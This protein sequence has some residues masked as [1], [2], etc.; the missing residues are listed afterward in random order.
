MTRCAPGI[1]GW[2]AQGEDAGLAADLDVGGGRRPAPGSVGHGHRPDAPRGR[3]VPR[4]RRACGTIPS[5]GRVARTGRP[6]GRCRAV[7]ARGARRPPATA[8]RAALELLRL[9]LLGGSRDEVDELVRQLTDSEVPLRFRAEATI[10]ELDRRWDA[11]RRRAGRTS[12]RDQRGPGRLGD[13][14]EVL[15]LLA[16]SLLLEAGGPPNSSPAW[17]VL[18]DRVRAI[19]EVAT[20]TLVMDRGGL[21]PRDAGDHADRHDEA[22]GVAPDADRDQ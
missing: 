9:A 11:A 18:V 17:R 14:R 4:G 13:D 10:L 20:P 7:A 3:A 2:P 16:R 21:P 22:R 12:A 1:A 8:D 15:R 6:P 19:E 5:P